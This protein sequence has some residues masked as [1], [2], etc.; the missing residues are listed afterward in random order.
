[1]AKRPK[2]A[3]VQIKARLKEPLRAAL[4]SA[5][6]DQGTSMNAEIVRRL[7]DS[8]RQDEAETE[9]FG[10]RITQTFLKALAISIAFVEQQTKKKWHED[11]DTWDAAMVAM[12]GIMGAFGGGASPDAIKQTTAA[13]NVS[14]GLDSARL[15]LRFGRLPD[16]K[17]DQMLGTAKKPRGKTLLT[18]PLKKEKGN[19]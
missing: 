10:G 16:D 3:T 13:A 1:M 12:Y 19:E 6:D 14:L 5:A 4:E 15:F 2:S 8:F 9:R 11:K 18:R 17:I 7:E